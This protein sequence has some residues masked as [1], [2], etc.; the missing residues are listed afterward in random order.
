MPGVRWR[1]NVGSRSGA[2]VIVIV[3]LAQELPAVVNIALRSRLHRT[4]DVGDV[5]RF[6]A[7]FVVLWRP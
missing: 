4:L 2:R 7:D 3:Q 6:G 1:S 5:L